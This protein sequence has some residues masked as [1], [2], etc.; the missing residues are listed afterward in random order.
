MGWHQLIRGYWSTRWEQQQQTY[1]ES[2]LED[3]R[4]KQHILLA[5]LVPCNATMLG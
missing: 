3:D 2:N 4:E 1:R 5:W